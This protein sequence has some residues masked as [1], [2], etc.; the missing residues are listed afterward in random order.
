MD[1]PTRNPSYWRALMSDLP[2]RVHEAENHSGSGAGVVSQSGISSHQRF[3]LSL[4][5]LTLSS[6]HLNIVMRF[7]SRSELDIQLRRELPAHG[8]TV[9]LMD[10]IRFDNVV[11]KLRSTVEGKADRSVGP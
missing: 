9:A 11:R 5:W 7:S 8:Q 4:L 2:V 1:T 3:P 6:E 10:V